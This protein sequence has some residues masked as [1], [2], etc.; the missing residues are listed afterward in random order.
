[1]LRRRGGSPPPAS[2]LATPSP[3]LAR[4]TAAEASYAL[5]TGLDFHKFKFDE[6]AAAR[7]AAPGA[8]P[9]SSTMAGVAVHVLSPKSAVVAYDRVVQRPGG[10]AAKTVAETRVWQVDDGGRWRQ[11]HFHRSAKA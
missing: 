4:P 2:A 3:S 5:L 10:A 8:P 9:S 1:M 11:V 6:A 7:A